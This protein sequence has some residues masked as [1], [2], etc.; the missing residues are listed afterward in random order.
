VLSPRS[1]VRLFR[2]SA[3]VTNPRSLVQTHPIMRYRL[4]AASGQ[5]LPPLFPGHAP[6]KAASL[7]PI[8]AACK[9]ACVQVCGASHPR[10]IPA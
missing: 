10:D 6:G 4:A 3:T 1:S 5:S 7:V 2:S 9:K 8:P